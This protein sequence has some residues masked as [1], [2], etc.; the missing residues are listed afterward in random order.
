M[1][2]VAHLRYEAFPSSKWK[3][4]P[5]AKKSPKQWAV[6]KKHG[7]KTAALTL[8]TEFGH[9]RYIQHISCRRFGGGMQCVAHAGSGL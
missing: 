2:Y 8:L 3:P 5:L 7:E 6:T 4:Y 9:D 1:L